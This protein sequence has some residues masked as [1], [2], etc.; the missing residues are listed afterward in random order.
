MY[1]SF[2]YINRVVPETYTAFTPSVNQNMV[3]LMHFAGPNGSTQLIDSTQ[4]QVITLFGDIHIDTSQSV[5]SGSSGYF[6][7]PAT[8]CHFDLNWTKNFDFHWFAVE[9]FTVDFRIRIDPGWTGGFL[10]FYAHN[11]VSSFSILVGDAA[12]GNHFQFYTGG[13]F[14]ITST[15]TAVPSTWYHVAVTRAS[16]NTRLFVNGVQEGV[17]YADFNDYGQIP[18]VDSFGPHIGADGAHSNNFF[19]WMEEL[20]ILKDV[21]AWTSN[22]ALPASPYTVT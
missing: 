12:S 20:R 11:N 5:F 15:T 3:L 2:D 14:Q 16:N 9:D 22:F 18:G 7:G 17:T 19:G 1:E 10:V 6:S 4:R 13:V 8:G 21:A